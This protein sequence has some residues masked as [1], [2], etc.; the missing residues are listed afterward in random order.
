MDYE[1]VNWIELTH[2]SSVVSS[3]EPLGSMTVEFVG[4]EVVN[5]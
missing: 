1:F 3:V 5:V 2:Q 4:P